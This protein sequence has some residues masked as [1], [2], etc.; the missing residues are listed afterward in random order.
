LLGGG[1]RRASAQL[2]ASLLQVNKVRRRKIDG[3]IG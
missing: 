1:G 3:E 2:G